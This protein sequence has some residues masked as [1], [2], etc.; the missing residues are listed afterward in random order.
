MSA[1]KRGVPLMPDKSD[2]LITVSREQLSL[3]ILKLSE[4]MLVFGAATG[5]IVGVFVTA[6]AWWMHS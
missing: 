4:R 2:I 6:F 1:A 5:F 3:L